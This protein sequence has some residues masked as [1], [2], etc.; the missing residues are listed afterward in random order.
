MT[1]VTPF[2]K[3]RC[4]YCLESFHPGDCAV[5]STVDPNRIRVLRPAPRPN[6]LEYYKS[7]TWIEEL[8]G[9]EYTAELAVRTCPLCHEPLFDN[10]EV[11]ENINIAIIGDAFSGKT[12]YIAVLIDQLK[13]SALMQNGHGY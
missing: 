9:P 12:H 3:I 8:V 7:R 10:I 13:R 4:P 5:V 1:P 11:C 2:T 6:T